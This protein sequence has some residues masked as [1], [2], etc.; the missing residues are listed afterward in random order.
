MTKQDGL[1]FALQ[2]NVS[3]GKGFA[4]LPQ[5]RIVPVGHTTTNTGLAVLQHGIA[6][7]DVLHK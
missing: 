3:I 5:G 2:G 6:V 1:S 4:R 7:D